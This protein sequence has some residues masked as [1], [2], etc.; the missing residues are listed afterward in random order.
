[1]IRESRP[2]PRPLEVEVFKKFQRWDVKY[3]EERK[4]RYPHLVPNDAPATGTPGM[5]SVLWVGLNPDPCKQ[6]FLNK[7][8]STGASRPESA[9]AGGRAPRSESCLSSVSNFDD[10]TALL[11]CEHDD[12]VFGDTFLHGAGEAEDDFFTRLSFDGYSESGYSE[13]QYAAEPLN[14]DTF[15][16]KAVVK[17]STG[18]R[19]RVPR[20]SSA[21]A[22]S[23]RAKHCGQ[24]LQREG[25]S[26]MERAFLLRE[27]RSGKANATRGP[28]ARLGSSV[29]RQKKGA[30]LSDKFDQYSDLVPAQPPSCASQSHS[31]AKENDER[32]GDAGTESPQQLHVMGQ[33]L[34]P[35]SSAGSRPS[36]AGLRP[37]SAGVRPSS[38][39]R[40][41]SALRPSSAG[42][43]PARPPLRELNLSQMNC[44]QHYMEQK[45]GLS[46]LG[47]F[48]APLEPVADPL[49]LLYCGVSKEGGGKYAYLK[50][51]RKLGPQAKQTRAMTA[52]EEIGWRLGD[53]HNPLR[54]PRQKPC[55]DRPCMICLL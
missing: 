27:L 44:N 45:M 33:S 8:G 3:A 52:T 54:P 36:S 30:W 29:G 43:L 34:R 37:A 20:P 41:F 23:R 38:S 1:M 13:S 46:R 18:A 28:P 21:P 19:Q 48:V 6:K 55:K 35:S 11:A 50:E 4:K 49:E 24:I 12:P 10:E 2:A 5:G 53:T 47:P 16:S 40:L 22:L 26:S 17:S 7:Q 39:A 32:L 51:R 42:V 31:A 14:A 15:D 9:P 25:A